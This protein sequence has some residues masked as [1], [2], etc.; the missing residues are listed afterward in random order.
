[1]LGVIGDGGKTP[2]F[3]CEQNKIIIKTLLRDQGF[4]HIMGNG[5]GMFI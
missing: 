5:N 2:L 1:M 4:Y 3:E